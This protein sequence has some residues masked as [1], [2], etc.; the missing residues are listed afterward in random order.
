[1]SASWVKFI[2]HFPLSQNAPKTGVSATTRFYLS[3]PL[4][5]SLE[6]RGWPRGHSDRCGNTARCTLL[7]RS[8]LTFAENLKREDYYAPGIKF[9]EERF[10]RPISRCFPVRVDKNLW[11]NMMYCRWDKT[12]WEFRR[13]T[14]SAN[15]RTIVSSCQ[16]AKRGVWIAALNCLLRNMYKTYRRNSTMISE[17][18]EFG[19]THIL[20]F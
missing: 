12:A 20:F 15:R 9:T 19:H 1:M 2:I 16:P 7:R 14:K 6:T 4:S 17:L 18:E 11:I 10:L 8:V 5:G 3:T 13:R